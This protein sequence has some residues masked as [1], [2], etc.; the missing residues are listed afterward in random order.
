MAS[1]QISFSLRVIRLLNAMLSSD[2]SCDLTSSGQYSNLES[3]HSSSSKAKAS[4]SSSDSSLC[5]T[6]ESCKKP[7]DIS[8]AVKI[9]ERTFGRNH[10][11]CTTI[12]FE[13]SEF[14]RDFRELSRGAVSASIFKSRAIENKSISFDVLEQ[15]LQFPFPTF[16]AVRI[17]ERSEL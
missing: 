11:L 1:R 5:V 3:P 13:H 10:H 17:G 6:P 12:C 14:S 4:R 2:D 8:E 15:C 7:S 9:S 16:E